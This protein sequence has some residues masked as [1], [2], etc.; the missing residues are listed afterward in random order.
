MT[1]DEHTDRVWL[2]DTL[3]RASVRYGRALHELS[4]LPGL[5][6]LARLHDLPEATDVKDAA[7]AIAKAVW[8]A[9]N[10]LDRLWD[11]AEAITEP[12]PMTCAECGQ[13]LSYFHGYD[14]LQHWRLAVDFPMTEV[15]DTDHEPRPLW[16]NP[17][18][19]DWRDHDTD[20]RPNT[21]RMSQQEGDTP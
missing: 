14:G 16:G 19:P 20:L 8:T 12:G 11:Y 6:A 15:L 9:I 10:E 3:T 2:V 21:T 5:L 4:A 1:P 17:P 18:R 7:E 13:R